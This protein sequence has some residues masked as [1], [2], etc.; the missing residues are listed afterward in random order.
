ML[1]CVDNFLFQIATFPQFQVYLNVTRAKQMISLLLLNNNFYP[2]VSY[3][4]IQNEK[5]SD[6]LSYTVS[7]T[8][9]GPRISCQRK[10]SE[11]YIA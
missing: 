3:R 5:E 8:R 7:V 2:P 9:Y 4:R 11:K 6:E 1:P 10:E